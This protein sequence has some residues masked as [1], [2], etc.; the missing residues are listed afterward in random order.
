MNRFYELN[1]VA[2]FFIIAAAAFVLGLFLFVIGLTTGGV[3]GFHKVAKDHSWV[4]DASAVVHTIETDGGF[5]AVE[6]TGM[7]DIVLVGEDYQD[8]AI[9][10]YHLNEVENLGP[11]TVV[12]RYGDNYNEPEVTMDNGTLEIS[13]IQDNTEQFTFGINLS[14]DTVWPTAII[15]CN[16]KE[17]KSVKVSSE[18]ADVEMM[19]VAF[20]NAD[21]ELN[22]GDVEFENIKSKGLKI[23]TEYGDIEVSGDLTGKTEL[24]SKDGDIEV[25]TLKNYEEYTIKAGAV[26]GDIKVG[27]TEMEIS[28]DE[29]GDDQEGVYQYTQKGGKDSLT[30]KTSYGDIEIGNLKAPK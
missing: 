12:L 6:A 4:N 21:I 11:G 18:Y 7:C 29:D 5:N 17:L 27:E 30:I 3:D 9:R 20:E 26:D 10:D 1:K 19:G 24:I 15:F 16:D 2:K 13:S 28:Y 25:D 23:D 14:D 22:D 8:K